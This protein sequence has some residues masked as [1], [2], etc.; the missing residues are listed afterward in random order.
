MRTWEVEQARGIVIVVHGAGEHHGRYKWLIDQFQ[1]QRFHVISG[2]LP[3]FGRTRGKRGHVEHF[4]Q[5]IDTVYSWYKEAEQ[6][7]LPIYLV[8]HSMGGLA[9]VQTALYKYMDI[10][11]IILSS[12]CF[13]LYTNPNKA[14]AVTGKVLH[15]ILP[16][17]SVKSRI[18]AE[19]ITRDPSIRAEFIKDQYR[20]STVTLRWYNELLR[21]IRESF[22][23][24]NQFPDIPLLV[25]QA[26]DD[27]VVDAHRTNEWFNALWISDRSFKR[28]PELYHELFN[29]PEKH[30]VFEYMMTFIDARLSV[31]ATI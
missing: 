31:S 30:D 23:Y 27:F 18:T 11:G 17:F 1:Q 28:F 16:G 12:P 24:A 6:F 14:V 5:Y 13:G 22:E 20:V 29:E 8:G 9:V 7:S 19:S 4:D 21:A 2:D 25:M 15:R 3:G 26:G 10:T